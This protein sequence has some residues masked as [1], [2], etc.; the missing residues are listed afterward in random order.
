MNKKTKKS[1]KKLF[2]AGIVGLAVLAGAREARATIVEVTEVKIIRGE[3]VG[4]WFQAIEEVDELIVGDV[5]VITPEVTNLGSETE[6]VLNMYGWDLSPENRVEV[7]GTSGLCVASYD[8]KPGESA[9]L[10][11]FCLE[12]AFKAEETGGVTMNI[13][14][15]DW[16]FENLCQY[17]FEFTVIPKPAM[18]YYVDADA[19]GLNDGSS[20]VNAYNYLQD[21]LAVATS[22]DE[23]W[24]AE[25]IYKPDQ[26]VGITPS[27]RTATFQLKNGVSIKGG[28][29]GFGE[30]DPNARDFVVY[31]TILSGDIGTAADS[32]DN[33][34]HIVRGGDNAILEGFTVFG[35]NANGSFQ[36]RNG[37]GGGLYNGDCR[38][39]VADCTFEQNAAF[40][41]GAI[42]SS[43]GAL[44]VYESKF[45]ANL[46][47]QGGALVNLNGRMTLSRC[48]MRNNSDGTIFCFGNA[49]LQVDSCV[50]DNNYGGWHTIDCSSTGN[51]IEVINSLFTH[52]V[53]GAI[54]CSYNSLLILNSTVVDNYT[55]T[56]GGGVCCSYGSL[57]AANC[58]MWGNTAGWDGDE[59]FGA[60]ASITVSYSCIA[61][62][63]PGTGNIS[64]N[65]LFRAPASE[66]YH[67]LAGSPCINAGDNT[68]VP[69]VTETDL[70]GR[71]R[72]IGGRIDMGAYEYSPPIPAEVRIVPRS[73]N[74]ASKGNWI[75][76]Y[77]SP[78]EGYDV[79]DINS[80]S[81]LLENEIEAE[82]FRFDEQQQIAV[83]RFSRSEVQGILGPGEVELTVSGELTD[84]TIFEG[85]DVI[86]VI[87]KSGR[88]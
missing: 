31:E 16:V 61:G 50:F 87:D 67:L 68:A 60:D 6:Y 1:L 69:P 37:T 53:G 45:L 65:P 42:F 83:A 55:T 80:K 54:N 25:G 20:W 84:G 77:I 46:A 24:V 35:G 58:I 9:V 75:T 49:A 47:L 62:G 4:G 2:F 38:L 88:K 41:G 64:M 43:G 10:I 7:I 72:I 76:C 71:P 63:Y 33:S 19:N 81:I 15:K 51:V 74:L 26:G 3:L 29:A 22:G 70:D 85:K 14:V 34:Y 59:I 48:V 12:Q 30:P 79:A 27:D 18:V 23:I 66:D 36:T 52:N 82:S 21:A 11:P 57:S 78:P 8:L 39:V 5:F 73:I 86:R 28:Y 17:T 56:F 32:S 40:N 44:A 13:Y